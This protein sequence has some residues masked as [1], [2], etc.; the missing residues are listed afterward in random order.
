MFEE[1]PLKRAWLTTPRGQQIT[2]WL[3]VLIALL[4]L[5][6]LSSQLE[7]DAQRATLKQL[8]SQSVTYCPI[9]SC[10][11]LGIARGLEVTDEL[12]L[13]ENE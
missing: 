8:D 3:G 10:G 9:A 5:L 13:E 1:V 7:L 2:M 12:V 6:P 11:G 4:A